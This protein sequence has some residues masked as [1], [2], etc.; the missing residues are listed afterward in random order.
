MGKD[1]GLGMGDDKGRGRGRAG[2][3]TTPLERS[4]QHTLPVR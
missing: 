1:K 3:V 2:A 4:L